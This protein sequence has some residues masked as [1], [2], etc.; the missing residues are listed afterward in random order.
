VGVKSISR[1]LRFAAP[2]ALAAGLVFSGGAPAWAAGTYTLA[3]TISP[4]SGTN[5]F[6]SAVDAATQTVYVAD[7]G[8][9]LL[10]ISESTNTV[11]GTIPVEGARMRSPSTRPPTRST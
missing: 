5:V 1:V 11:T 2:V 8:N 7:S 10:V 9:E 3:A 6:Y 4:P